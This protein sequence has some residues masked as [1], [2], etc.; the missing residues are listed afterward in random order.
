M[1][2]ETV[3]ENLAN[4]IEYMIFEEGVKYVD[5]AR[6]ADIAQSSLYSYKQRIGLISHDKAIRLADAMGIPLENLCRRTKKSN[7]T[8]RIRMDMVKTSDISDAEL[9]DVLKILATPSFPII[10]RAVMGQPFKNPNQINLET[11]SVHIGSGDLINSTKTYIEIHTIGVDSLQT[12]VKASTTELMVFVSRLLRAH[13]KDLS[14][15][16]LYT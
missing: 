8:F 4:T 5:V 15:R 11:S 12:D 1:D 10:Y 2:R 6:K 9:R 16:V 13:V 7:T 14:Y 3:Q